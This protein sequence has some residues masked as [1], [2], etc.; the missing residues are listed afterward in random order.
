MGNCY[1]WFKNPGSAGEREWSSMTIDGGFPL[2]S[3]VV[4]GDIDGD[5]GAD[6]L[7][8][9]GT[10][11]ALLWYKPSDDPLVQPWGRQV[12]D[13][14]PGAREPVFAKLVDLNRDGRLDF[15]V[16]MGGYG[17]QPGMA[18]WYENDGIAEGR[19][20]WKKHSIGDIPRMTDVAIGDIDGD[21]AIDVVASGFMPGEIAWFRNS[22]NP[23]ARWTKQ[24]VKQDWP[25]VNQVIVA[26]F[27][28]DGRVDLAAIADYGSMELRWW[29]N[30]GLRK[31]GGP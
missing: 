3:C 29:R 11:R 13:L 5:G 6:L 9:S 31:N 1:R 14:T 30:T 23:A 19:V 27:D 20:Q 16:A 10:S 21:G 28:K 17:N 4:A 7:V 24:I 18:V 15:V 2:A 26:D 22:G 12:V 25:N 8:T